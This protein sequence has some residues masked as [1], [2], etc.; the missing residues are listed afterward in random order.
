MSLS[1]SAFDFLWKHFGLHFVGVDHN[2]LT[3]IDNLHLTKLHCF[4]Q[5]FLM[6]PT[7]FLLD[8]KKKKKCSGLF[9]VLSENLSIQ[10]GIIQHGIKISKRACFCSSSA[11]FLRPYSPNTLFLLTFDILNF[12]LLGLNLPL[13]WKV[14]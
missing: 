11:Q 4:G 3:Y 13:F 8:F 5:S 2:S 12:H 14:P 9:C 10:I 7:F 6:P 1:Y